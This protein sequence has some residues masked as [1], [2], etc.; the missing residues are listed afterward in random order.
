MF[1][2]LFLLSL[3]LRFEFINTS[4]TS[5]IKSLNVL[6]ANCFENYFQQ[7]CFCIFLNQVL[8]STIVLYLPLFRLSTTCFINEMKFSLDIC[9]NNG[10]CI[11]SNFHC[12]SRVGG[13]KSNLFSSDNDFVPNST[14]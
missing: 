8:Q 5:F 1:K 12:S 6:C 14:G 7:K 3:P 10:F 2:M 9:N 11:S 13:L 4:I